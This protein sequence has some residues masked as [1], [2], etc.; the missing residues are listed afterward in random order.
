MG[1]RVNPIWEGTRHLRSWTPMP[2]LG[3]TPARV[4]GVSVR[5]WLRVPP[6]PRRGWAP[7]IVAV[8]RRSSPSCAVVIPRAY[9]TGVPQSSMLL[10]AMNSCDEAA[11]VSARKS[12]M[13]F[14]SRLSEADVVITMTLYYK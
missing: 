3:G 13:C 1:K 11:P 5:T 14:R 7:G 12:V 8:P 10:R 4:S 2:Y 9:S 6:P